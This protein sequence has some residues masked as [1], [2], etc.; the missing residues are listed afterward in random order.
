[1]ALHDLAVLPGFEQ[2]DPVRGTY[3][4]RRMTFPFSV[5]LCFLALCP[6]GAQDRSGAEQP[7]FAVEYEVTY[8]GNTPILRHF[9]VQDSTKRSCQAACAGDPNCTAYTYVKANGYTPNTPPVCYLF[10]GYGP[11]SYSNCC[12]TGTKQAQ[13]KQPVP[14]PPPYVKTPPP[15]QVTRPPGAPT[16]VSV[17]GAWYAEGNHNGLH[18][19]MDELNAPGTWQFGGG[20]VVRTWPDHNDRWGTWQC[21]ATNTY[22]LNRRNGTFYTEVALGA[23]GKLHAKDGITFRH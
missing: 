21:V 19:F 3:N 15:G 4:R 17:K 10:S 11:R 16:C 14:P 6:A 2:N 23:D 18:F 8:T 12:V 5:I 20:E 9:G 1:M 7:G 13:T 22:R